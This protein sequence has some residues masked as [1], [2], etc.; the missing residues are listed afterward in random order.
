MFCQSSRF[1][2]L[3]DQCLQLI[4][5]YTCRVLYQQLD[6]YFIQPL[7]QINTRNN[8]PLHQTILEISH[9]FMKLRPKISSRYTRPTPWMFSHFIRPTKMFNLYTS[10]TPKVFSQY[11]RPTPTIFSHY[12]I[13][14]PKIFSYFT[15][16]T[17]KCLT[18]TSYQYQKNFSYYRRLSPKISSLYRNF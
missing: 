15:R 3:L 1:T 2:F 5:A 8:L 13:P 9:F 7:C 16:A 12:A 18:T 6:I 4:V 10:P 17:P 11:I 14:V